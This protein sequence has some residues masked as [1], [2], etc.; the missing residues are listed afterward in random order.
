MSLQKKDWSAIIKH[1]QDSYISAQP[2]NPTMSDH[3]L[4][5]LISIPQEVGY[6]FTDRNFQRICGDYLYRVMAGKLEAF[7]QI[8]KIIINTD[9][10]AIRNAYS[11]SRNFKVVNAYVQEP[12]ES[13][14]ELT[15]DKVTAAMLEHADGE[16]FLQLGP[17]FPFLKQQTIE[18]AIQSYDKYVVNPDEDYERYHYDSLFTIRMLNR[19]YF[20]TDTDFIREDRPNTFVED[21]IM[22]FFNR[23]TFA[24]NGNRK[25]GKKPFGYGVDEI[26][27]LAIDSEEN[28]MIAQYIDENRHRFPNVFGR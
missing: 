23:T 14:F 19:R 12:G 26:E 13:E 11:R 20:D 28:L 17:I 2:N 24:A 22:H 21:G 25:V 18:N 16:H 8:D 15:S 7:G 27:N 9:S 10:D 3:S 1:T 5:A 4:T 6:T